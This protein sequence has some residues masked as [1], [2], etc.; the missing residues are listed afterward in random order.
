MRS[1]SGKLPVCY[2]YAVIFICGFFW[3]LYFSLSRSH[4]YTLF[5]FSL[6]AIL[7]FTFPNSH[8]KWKNSQE[9]RDA[10]LIFLVKHIRWSCRE[11]IKKE[12]NGSFCEELLGKNDF[13]AILATFCCDEYGP[14][15]SEAVQ[16]ISADKKNYQKCSW[17]FVLFWIAKNINPWQWKRLVTRTP[18]T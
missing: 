3:S 15:P 8:K 9:T 10:L 1:F 5:Y 12:E 16:K 2:T 14:N 6:I 7:T 4:F 17:C 13:E 18:P 11:Y